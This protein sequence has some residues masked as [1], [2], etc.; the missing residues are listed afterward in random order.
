M[1]KVMVWMVL[2][3][4]ISGVMAKTT[5]EVY[6]ADDLT[7]FDG[8]NIMVGT[9]LKLIVTSDA[10]DFWSGGLF[11]NGNNRDLAV[12]SGSGN[13]PNSR[14]YSVSHLKDAGS[15]ALV[16]R[17][18]DS[19]IEGFDLFSDSNCVPGDW[20]EIDYTALAPGDLNVGF[21]EYSVSWDDPNEFF[22]IHQVPTADFNTD[23]I[24]NFLDY[25]LLASCWEEDDCT[26]P[27]GC[28]KAD[29]DTDGTV[30][31]NDLLL[32][33][34][35]WL[36]GT[37]EPSEPNEPDPVD[38]LPDPNMIYSIVGA[39]GLDE[40]TI[41]IGQTVTLYVDMNTIDSNEVW[42]FD[43]EVVISD[44]NLGSIDNT[45]YDPNDPPGDG[46][47]RILA[48]PGRWSIFDRWGPGLQQEDGIYLSGL[49]V[50]GAFEDGHL[51][52]FEFTCQDQGDVKLD[53]INWDT[54]STSGQK[55]CPTLESILIHQNEPAVQSMMS[56]DRMSSSTTGRLAGQLQRRSRLQHGI[57]LAFNGIS[58]SIASMELFI[59]D[60]FFWFSLYP[61]C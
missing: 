50:G 10:N 44:P 60:W 45:A 59:W 18:E 25:S 5:L 7:L 34:D 61:F 49:C 15:E 1:K 29:I 27:N 39:N 32:F 56:L 22:T 51:A 11:I 14:D 55:L 46:T 30:D 40:I 13:S 37:P 43:V 16:T 52:S 17:W 4:I 26:D 57:L 47:A 35:Y 42:N 31:V 23:G 38:P 12:L 53:L 36:W 24:V 6:D 19:V 48:S 21:Y 54:T 41:D 2:M 9:E 28:Q 20:F 8:R 33:T 3:G 58:Q